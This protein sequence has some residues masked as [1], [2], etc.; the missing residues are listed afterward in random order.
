MTPVDSAAIS[1]HIATDDI[2]KYF[3]ATIGPI[4]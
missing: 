2:E 1:Q 4:D 3:A